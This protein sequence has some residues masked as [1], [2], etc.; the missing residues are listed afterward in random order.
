M[1]PA[2]NVYDSTGRPEHFPSVVLGESQVT[3]QRF[4]ATVHHTLHVWQQEAGLV[5]AKV[6]CG[7]VVR[8]LHADMQMDGAIQ[9][10]NF[11]AYDMHVSETRV[12]RDPHGS[13]SHAVITVSSI[14][15]ER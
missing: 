4:T 5:M 2:D 12:M 1:I 6:A 11:I 10:D 13:F 8:A 3:Y 14:V 15:K 7:H 9:T